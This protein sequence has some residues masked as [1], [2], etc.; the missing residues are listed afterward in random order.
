MVLGPSAMLRSEL[1]SRVTSFFG[2]EG[3]SRVC[4]AFVVVVG[5]GG[6][7]SHVAN[8]LVRS[9]VGHIRL[10]DFDQ[11]TLSSLNRHACATQEDVGKSKAAVLQATL[12]RVAPWCEI[13]AVVEM[14]RGCDAKRLLGGSPTFVIDCIDDVIT[15]AELIAYCID[16]GL[17]FLTSLGAGGKADPT[18]LRIAPLSDCINDPLASKIKWKLKKH[19]ISADDVMSVFSIEK[20]ICNLLP[21]DD[22]Q[23]A[24]PQDF[25]AVDY[26]R[27]RVM[28]VLGTSPA[29][30][31]QAMASYV[32]CSMAGREFQP[33]SCERLSRNL[34]HKLK[35]ALKRTELQRFGG[36]AEAGGGGGGGGGGGEGTP[37]LL[38]R[39]CDPQR[40]EDVD[41]DD[42]DIEFVVHLVWQG[43]CALTAKRFGGHAPLVLVRWNASLSPSPTNLVLMIQTSAN[44]L[45]KPENVGIDGIP[46]C[47]PPEFV[48]KVNTRLAWAE[49]LRSDALVYGSCGIRSS[50]SST[51]AL[52][53]NVAKKKTLLTDDPIED[54]LDKSVRDTFT[55]A[56]LAMGVALLVGFC[57]GR[58]R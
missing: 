37:A 32:L 26:L 40:E 4:D 28:P 54:F 8:M 52:T 58:W 10:I 14:F 46:L 45:L 17:K 36:A 19:N 9:G 44:L 47:F 16:N 15:K 31:G 49:T 3:A 2:D 51:R 53:G 56:V 50:T 11:V 6:V 39:D 34:K 27:L 5:L 13:E 35:E 57:I 21:L 29:I 24:N 1:L 12:Q 48:K 25:G 41:L 38:Q 23:K 7:G 33:E 22:D 18:R 20:P 42:E 55:E 30:F 43:R